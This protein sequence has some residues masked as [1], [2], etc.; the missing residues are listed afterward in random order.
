MNHKT[1]AFIANIRWKTIEI[2]GSYLIYLLHQQLL[3]HAVD[4]LFYGKIGSIYGTIFFMASLL[5][6]GFEAAAAPRFSEWSSS[7]QSFRNFITSETI[8]TMLFGIIAISTIGTWWLSRL[9]NTAPLLACALLMLFELS[10]KLLKTILN[11]LLFNNVTALIEIGAMISYIA[12]IWLLWISKFSFTLQSIFLSH[13]IILG[14]SAFIYAAIILQWYRLL[15]VQ[16]IQKFNVINTNQNRLFVGINQTIDQCFS[17]NL[18][19][20]LIASTAGFAFAGQYYL[21]ATT[22]TTL[23][24][25]IERIHGS[26]F[27]AHFSH[28]IPLDRSHHTL[29]ASG[30]IGVI[31]IAGI[32]LV[33]SSLFHNVWFLIGAFTLLSIEYI[34]KIKEKRM[35]VA[36]D[37]HMLIFNSIIMVVGLFGIITIQCTILS[38]FLLLIMLRFA[39]LTALYLKS[40]LIEKQKQTSIIS[41][42]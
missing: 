40:S 21:L 8:P 14:A 42:E 36:Q 23:T 16:C 13:A 24:M 39:I 32:F 4:P 10:R 7:Q 5:R 37:T 2:L 12:I 3:F 19:V 31:I 17:S 41:N 29:Y 25:M 38:T 27:L 34:I 9:T 30:H 20:P 15:P 11:L 28:K 1:T 18:I 35:I 26:L 6:L 22:F 33:T